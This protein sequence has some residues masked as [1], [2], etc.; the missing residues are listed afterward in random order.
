MDSH[1]NDSYGHPREKSYLHVY[2]Y[3]GMG[4]KLKV[5]LVELI[6]PE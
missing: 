6:N 2:S 3:A 5:T 4:V 1:H